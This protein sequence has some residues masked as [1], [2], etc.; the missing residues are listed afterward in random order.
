MLTRLW[1]DW[2]LADIGQSQV[3]S[4]ST[5]CVLSLMMKEKRASATTQAHFKPLFASGLLAS[6]PTQLSKSHGQVQ[7]KGV[8][9]NF[10][11]PNTM[12]MLSILSS[13]Q[14]EELLSDIVKDAEIGRGEEWEPVIE[15]TTRTSC[16]QISYLVKIFVELE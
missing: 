14:W 8:G 1:V 2:E 15:S 6:R 12:Q 7:S 5:P 10:I 4:T 11:F 13:L 16:T 9:K 3:G